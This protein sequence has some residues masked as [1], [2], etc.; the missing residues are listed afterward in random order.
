MHFFVQQIAKFCF[1]IIFFYFY[2]FM[3]DPFKYFVWLY[4]LQRLMFDGLKSQFFIWKKKKRLHRV[5][6]G[7]FLYIVQYSTVQYCTI[8]YY[9]VQYNTAKYSTVQYCSVQHNNTMYLEN[10]QFRWCRGSKLHSGYSEGTH[11]LEQ[12][13]GNRGTR[14]SW[15]RSCCHDAVY[16]GRLPRESPPTPPRR[17]RGGRRRLSLIPRPV[18]WRL[19]SRKAYPATAQLPSWCGCLPVLQQRRWS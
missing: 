16:P 4:L 8:L 17:T 19:H 7:C 9:I 14:S 2:F 10:F 15:S 3:E 6:E 13:A 12:W 5:T 18:G 11:A 1:F